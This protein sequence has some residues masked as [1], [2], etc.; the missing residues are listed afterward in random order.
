MSNTAR[1][2]FFDRDGTLCRDVPYC[3]R[4]EDLELL[5]GVIPAIKDVHLL[6]FKVV[7][8]TNQ[9]GIARGYFTVPDLAVIHEKLR[10]ELA[11]ADIILDGIFFCPHHPEENCR[12]RKPQPGLL[13]SSAAALDIDLASSYM[14]GNALSDIQA[15]KNAGCRTILVYSQVTT[16]SSVLPDYTAPDLFSAVQWIASIKNRR[17]E[18]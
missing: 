1:A 10:R 13:L 4:P 7:V 12:C 16:P 8:I 14:V 5:P 18:A 9:S 15:G 2:V 3:S 11:Q 6:G 17:S